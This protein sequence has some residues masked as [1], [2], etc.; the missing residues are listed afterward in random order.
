MTQA[1]DNNTLKEDLFQSL[2]VLISEPESVATT[3]YFRE[4][5]DA[6]RRLDLLDKA[7]VF[8]FSTVVKVA[9]EGYLNDRGLRE[10][11]RLARDIAPSLSWLDEDTLDI[12]LDLM[13]E[14]V[15]HCRTDHSWRLHNGAEWLHEGINTVCGDSVSAAILPVILSG[16]GS[17]SSTASFIS[18][19]TPKLLLNIESNSE[20]HTE[21]ITASLSQYSTW[22][23]KID[24]EWVQR[25]LL[26]DSANP[27]IQ[28]SHAFWQGFLIQRKWDLEF[29]RSSHLAARINAL[30]I[31][32]QEEGRSYKDYFGRESEKAFVY[33]LAELFFKTPKEEQLLEFFGD[34][35]QRESNSY[36]LK[37]WLEAVGFAINKIDESE[38]P[39]L[40]DEI[41]TFRFE[42]LLRTLLEREIKP[43]S[44]G[45]IV[46]CIIGF[47]L[48]F[49]EAFEMVSKFVETHG[50]EF[51]GYSRLLL[52]L[53][54][55]AGGPYHVLNS[56]K[57]VCKLIS[58]FVSNSLGDKD[59][60]DWQ[61]RGIFSK[62]ASDL[63][64][65][66][67][68][69]WA[70]LLSVLN[71]RRFVHSLDLLSDLDPVHNAE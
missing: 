41:F 37:D 44:V 63:A 6:L 2:A 8:R 38:Y 67:P 22:I 47:R 65:S 40:A 35:I 62:Y 54:N 70:N 52:W 13:G 28:K 32:L 5:W 18:S 20:S 64:V 53:E 12:W 3:S 58:L 14:L 7:E 33:L 25:H 17:D 16:R 66:A 59:L 55:G 30:L 61:L 39:G 49:N 9:L 26:P 56:P 36:L 68:M 48:T 27:D 29:L 24:P 46:D 15:S 1:A 11:S 60:A 31:L 10:I 57:E 45:A 34:F 51:S 69:E 23:S 43:V 19:L 4:E 71:E 21:P 50:C 42:P